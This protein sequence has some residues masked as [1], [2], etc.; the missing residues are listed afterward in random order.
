[1]SR[2]SRGK[3]SF[4][5]PLFLL[6]IAAVSLLADGAKSID[7][8]QVLTGFDG[9]PIPSQ[10]AKVTTGMTLS[11]AAITALENV[12]PSDQGSKGEAKFKMD[13]LARKVYQNKHASLTIEELDLIKTRIGEAWGPIVVGPAWRIL[14]KSTELPAIAEKPGTANAEPKAK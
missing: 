6:V 2:N 4:M 8:T 7:F 9:K 12:L 1:M 3:L 14:S 11:D 13:E 5:K 10:D